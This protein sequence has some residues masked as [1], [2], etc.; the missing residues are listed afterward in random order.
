M[1]RRSGNVRA[2]H[3]RSRPEGSQDTRGLCRSR[4]ERFVSTAAPHGQGVVT[5]RCIVLTILQFQTE[6]DFLRKLFIVSKV[7]QFQDLQR[8]ERWRKQL[9]SSEIG[10]KQVP[11]SLGGLCPFEHH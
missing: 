3:P 1:P 5:L 6:T 2:A 7:L 11:A 8:Q 10:Q 9:V 4:V